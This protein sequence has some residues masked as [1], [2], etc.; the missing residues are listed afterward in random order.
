MSTTTLIVEILII[1]IQTMIWVLLF[2][3]CLTGQDWLLHSL[4]FIK[5]YTN[6][7]IIL[8][9]SL[10]YTLGV[11]MDRIGD[12]FYNMVNPKKYFINF[13]LI[14]NTYNSAH[15]DIRMTILNHEQ[16]SCDFL[17]YVRS[18]I[19][20]LRATFLNSIFYSTFGTLTLLFK[21]SFNNKYVFTLIFCI[22]S[23]LFSFLCFWALAMLQI[24]Y[25][26]RMKQLEKYI[27]KD[28]N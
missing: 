6:F 12:F 16:K 4:N 8:F 10:S 21:F 19:R 13:S 22:F 25:E 23:L 20:I 3:F 7:F 26:R 5:D 14:R 18:R 24:T 28:A 27:G 17:D 1:G 9:L 11:L 15:N 2:F